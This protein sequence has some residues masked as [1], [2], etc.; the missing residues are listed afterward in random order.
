MTDEKALSVL[1]SMGNCELCCQSDKCERKSRAMT[2]E[3]H[4]RARLAQKPKVTR[5]QVAK[6]ERWFY[7]SLEVTLPVAT[8][9]TKSVL[10]I[11]G[12]EVEK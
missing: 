10:D 9:R 8:D 3:D 7:S 4:L 5:E 12:L 6:L 2:A 1:N 11:L